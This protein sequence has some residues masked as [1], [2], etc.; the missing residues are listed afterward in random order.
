M[1]LVYKVEVAYT[2]S[3]LAFA[4]HLKVRHAVRKSNLYGGRVRDCRVCIVFMRRIK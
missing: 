4:K 3:V 2:N 1:A